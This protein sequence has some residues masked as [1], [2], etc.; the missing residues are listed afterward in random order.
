MA[1]EGFKL[2]REDG[3][4]WGFSSTDESMLR[5]DDRGVWA[6]LVERGLP[7]L[8]LTQVLGAEAVVEQADD[9]D[10]PS[11]DTGDDV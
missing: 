7:E 10:D 3:G 8:P 4:I 9:D 6:R 1:A 2:L 5:S 11:T